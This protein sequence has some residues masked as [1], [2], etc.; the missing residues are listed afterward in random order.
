MVPAFVLWRRL[1]LARLRSRAE[2]CAEDLGEFVEQHFL[3]QPCAR[4]HESAMVLLDLSPN[5][6][7]AHYQC[8]HCGKRMRAPAGTPDARDA[9]AM[10][11]AFEALCDVHDKTASA[12]LELEVCF[13]AP[14]APLPFERRTRS[15][16]PEPIRHEVWR[17]DQGACVGCGARQNLQFDHIIPLSHGGAAS[18]QNLQLLCRACNQ[19]KG[20]RI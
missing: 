17:R 9:L 11:E 15:P 19:A 1:R 10:L 7:S 6:R 2:R 5:V 8:D 3:I 14:E 12:K 18:A 16:I 4:C 13:D 20:A